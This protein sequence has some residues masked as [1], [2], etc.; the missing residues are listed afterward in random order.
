MTRATGR[1]PSGPPQP[2]PRRYNAVLR[3]YDAPLHRDW[4]FWLTVGLA[5]LEA[6]SVLTYPGSPSGL[7]RWLDTLLAVLI[8]TLLFGVVPAWI[9]LGVRRW[10]WRRRQSSPKPPPG[11]TP[12]PTSAPR[13]AP[14]A[15]ADEVPH[16]TPPPHATTQPRRPPPPPPHGPAHPE[17]AYPP[18]P[19]PLAAARRAFPHPVARTVHE[20]QR[21]HTAKDRHEALLEAGETLAATVAVTAAGLLT[22]HGTGERNLA[23]LRTAL[24]GTGTTFGT[25]TVWL[26]HLCKVARERT[27]V[28]PGLAEALRDDA[29][30]A[31]RPDDPG[32]AQFLD[33]L[34][35]ERNRT[36]H[37]DKPRTQEEAALRVAEHRLTLEQALTSAQF[38][39][40]L[41]W[42][43]TVSCAYQRRTGTFE[44]V[45]DHLMGDH[46]DFDRLTFSC[47]AP[48]ADDTVYVL[49]PAGPV[50][51]S[52]FVASLYCAQCG[53]REICHANNAG[54][55]NRPAAY[56]SF[57]RGHVIPYPE[58]DEE[59]AA[60]PGPRPS[61]RPGRRTP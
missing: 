53:R 4:A 20:M 59:I 14:P 1:A 29:E 10:R 44:V 35:G 43:L 56:K 57:G 3:L 9:R 50:A 42:L 32:L 38:L 47:P 55:R 49:S 22:A 24:A 52:P 41:P 15:H 8:F 23:E 33:R 45:A 27:D 37:G 6:V 19:D 21:A 36:S 40:G 11:A 39:T 51:L 58:L 61:P 12:T 17:S 34:K 60:L 48:V 28:V 30:M 13:T 25:W 31:A 16:T 18:S 7:P 5:V 2:S 54:R 46:P 26:H